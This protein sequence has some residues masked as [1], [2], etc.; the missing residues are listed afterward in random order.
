MKAMSMVEREMDFAVPIPNLRSRTMLKGT[1][2]RGTYVGELA[3]MTGMFKTFPVT[4][5]LN[6]VMRYLNQDTTAS[7]AR[8][9]TD[10]IIGSAVIGGLV[11]GAKSMVYGRDP[12]DM[13]T[14]EFWGAALLQGG[15]LGILGDFL[16][17]NVNRFG[18]GF[19]STL[20]G[21]GAGFGT[22]LINLT[23]G[24]VIEATQGKD[25]KIGRELTDF[26]ARYTPGT[27]IW[28][29]RLAY[30]RLI[31]DQLRRMADPNARQR[32]R[33]KARNLERHF[34]QQMWWEHGEMAPSRAPDLSA[35]LGN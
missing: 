19:G 6:N 17:Q 29:V 33:R 12:R 31:L 9:M 22:D 8:W 27:G 25:M 23:A 35:A 11:I 16:F 34:G 21:P 10:F 32:F 18:A 1:S 30:E 14:P 15:G 20:A 28:Y 26:V 4:I 13:T 24:N 7:K 5:T 3:R 2:D